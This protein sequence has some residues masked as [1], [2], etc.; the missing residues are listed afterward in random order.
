M[1][2]IYFGDIED[3]LREYLDGV[4]SVSTY[5]SVPPD[6]PDSFVVVRRLGGPKRNIVTDSATVA[7][8][9]YALL[10]SQASTLIQE[11]RAHIHA[12]KGQTIGG[13]TVYRTQEFAGPANLPD[14]LTDQPRYTLNVSIDVR[15]LP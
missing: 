12:L 3:A 11:A 14:P 5:L 2:A 15:A 4:L 7:V 13:M 9:A 6:R 10:G 1:E 8:D